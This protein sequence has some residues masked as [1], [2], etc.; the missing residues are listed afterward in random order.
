MAA[1]MADGQ[2]GGRGGKTRA[3]DRR[4]SCSMTVDKRRSE[5]ITGAGGIGNRYLKGRDMP[6]TVPRPDP[7]AGGA[8]GDAGD[9]RSA[10]EQGQQGVGYRQ[11]RTG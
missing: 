9:L 5:G 1:A 10:R 2:G 3:G 7:G 11:T 6:D 8:G 4:P